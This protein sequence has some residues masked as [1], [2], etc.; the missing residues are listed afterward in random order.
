MRICVFDTETTSLEK[1]FCYN[2]GFIIYDTN[3]KKILEKKEFVI[4]Q[5]WHNI[6]LFSTAYYSEKRPLYVKR[7]RAK[8]ITLEK[9]GYV[10]QYMIRTF[11]NYNV[12]FAYAYNASFDEKVFNFNCEFFKNINPFDNIPIVDIMGN[13]HNKIAFSKAF[14]SF[15]ENYCLFT[16][17]GNYSTTAE[18]LTKF[19]R[20]DSTFQEEH[21]ALSDSEIELEILCETISRGC[22]WGKSYKRYASV[23]RKIVKPLEIIDKRRNQS[24]QLDYE[25]IRINREKTKIKLK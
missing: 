4:E 19:F 16:E 22:E 2:V 7:M 24:F 13:L 18:T 1:P 5:I 17:A 25:K 20:K 21:T 14:Q 23:K 8:K 10:C 9:W 11:K 3:I 15:C 6:P 12:Q